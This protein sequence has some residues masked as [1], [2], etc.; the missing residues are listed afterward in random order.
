MPNIIWWKSLFLIVGCE[1][2]MQTYS[3]MWAFGCHF[4]IETIDTKKQTCDSTIGCIFQEG[5]DIVD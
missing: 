1:Y 5:E 2:E 3:T 4:H